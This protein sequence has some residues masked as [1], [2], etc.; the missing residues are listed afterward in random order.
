VVSLGRSPRLVSAVQWYA[1]LGPPFAW[2][3]QL[4][5]GYAYAEAS[6]G[7][8]RVSAGVGFHQWQVIVG[9]TMAVVAAAAWAAA[10]LL[11]AAVGRG[12]VDDPLGRVKFMSTL[13]II[14]GAIFVTLILYT[15]AGT[16]SLEGCR[17]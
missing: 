9:A 10:I 17:P 2:V 3:V 13:G 15:L 14:V 5:L 12:E 4:F 8:A 16:L 11:H 7:T 1:S 6:C